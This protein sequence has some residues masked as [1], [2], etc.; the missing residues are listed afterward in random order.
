VEKDV[1]GKGSL[2]RAVKEKAEE[3]GCGEAK[4]VRGGT[5]GCLSKRTGETIG[6]Q[7]K[8]HMQGS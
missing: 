3:V 8:V 2:E 7:C 5:S 6:S 4:K 1:K